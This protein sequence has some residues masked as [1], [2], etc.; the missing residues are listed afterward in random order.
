MNMHGPHFAQELPS[1]ESWLFLYQLASNG[2]QPYLRSKHHLSCYDFPPL[3]QVSMNATYNV[4]LP[5]FSSVLTQ[6]WPFLDPV[7]TSSLTPNLTSSPCLGLSPD[8]ISIF[9][10]FSPG[11]T[12]LYLPFFHILSEPV[13][14]GLIWYEPVQT[15]LNWFELACIASR[16]LF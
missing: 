6:Q 5:Y 15:S 4:E 2:K 1:C 7:L 12:R 11:K 9:I 13:P 8:L 3:M 10:P 14:A 16:L